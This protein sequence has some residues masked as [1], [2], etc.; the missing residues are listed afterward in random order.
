MITKYWNEEKQS[1]SETKVGDAPRFQEDFRN[2]EE[3]WT[4]DELVT[5]GESRALT[6]DLSWVLKDEPFL[7]EEEVANEGFWREGVFIEDL[8]AIDLR[9]D[10]PKVPFFEEAGANE[11]GFS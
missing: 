6:A 2:D 7:I 10:E 1:T 5:K 3:S 11:A 4:F 9:V 8:V